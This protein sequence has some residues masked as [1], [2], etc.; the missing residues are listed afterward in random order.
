MGL[1]REKE[2]EKEK[3][4]GKEKEKEKK[5]IAKRCKMILSQ[6]SLIS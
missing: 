1:C 5:G 2:K 4:K 6:K 3:E